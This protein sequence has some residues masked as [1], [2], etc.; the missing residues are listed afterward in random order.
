V[1][2]TAK[3]P[4]LNAASRLP[5][6]DSSR[7]YVASLSP[8]SKL[9]SATSTPLPHATANPPDGAFQTR[10]NGNTGRMND[11]DERPSDVLADAHEQDADLPGDELGGGLGNTEDGGA[12][13]G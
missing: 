3:M 11:R 6:S 8:G 1:I 9:A 2:A 12:S 7:T 10:R 13:E 5:P 4:S